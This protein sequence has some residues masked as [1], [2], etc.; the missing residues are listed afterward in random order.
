MDA[1][2]D[3]TGL[4]AL[5]AFVAAQASLM[6]VHAV[7]HRRFHRS[8]RKDELPSAQDQSL[9]HTALFVPCKGCDLE[10]DANLCALF[11]QRYPSFEIVFTVES[12]QDPAVAVIRDLQAKYPQVPSRLVVAGLARD[13]GQKV[14]NLR[15]AT[16]EISPKTQILAFVDSDARPH[17]DFLMRLINRL[18]S[19]KHAIS[20]GYRWHLPVRMTG[21]DL[22][23]AAT[24]NWLTTLTSSHSLNLVWGGAWAIQRDVFDRLELREGWDGALSD[25]LVLSRHLRMA[26]LSVAYEPHCLVAS[27]LATSWTGTLEFLRRQY[28]VTRVCVP[29]WW[30]FGLI[31]TLSTLAIPVVGATLSVRM[32]AAGEAWGW[33]LLLVLAHYVAT[34]ARL[35]MGMAAV[36]PFIPQDRDSAGSIRPVCRLIVLGWPLITMTHLA[37]LVGSAIGRTLKWRGI[38]YRLIGPRQTVIQS[39]SSGTE[40]SPMG[41][42]ESARPGNAVAPHGPHFKL[43]ESSPTIPLRRG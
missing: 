41:Q 1:W 2:I 38:S 12:E 25:D 33:P 29:L 21:I 40:A 5:A 30:T 31:A 35:L 4:A 26:G 13:C 14:H 34:S 24:N 11:E 8:R 22:I 27:P 39:R 43:R 6:L 7:E 16:A 36:H 3:G 37:G 20:T 23:H 19:G 42:T 17:G 28:L 9:P 18:D 15:A 10:L 32:A